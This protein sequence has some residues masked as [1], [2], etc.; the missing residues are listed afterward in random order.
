V[1][2]GREFIDIFAIE[3]I[4]MLAIELFIDPMED[5]DGVAALPQ[6]M[7]LP[8]LD[9]GGEVLLEL[10]GLWAAA[11]QFKEVDCIWGWSGAA[12]LCVLGC[13]GWEN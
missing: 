8:V 6:G 3:F 10:H 2:A 7:V 4:D 13:R 1:G 11:P 9:N 5:S 12:V